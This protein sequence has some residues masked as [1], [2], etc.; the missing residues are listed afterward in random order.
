MITSKEINM[1]YDQFKKDLGIKDG[2]PKLLI[3]SKPISGSVAQIK[4]VLPEFAELHIDDVLYRNQLHKEYIYQV[5]YHEFTHIVD[6]LSYFNKKKDK[7]KWARFCSHIQN[8][9][10]LKLK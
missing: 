1:V 3:L 7:Y 9:M 5:L 6:E 8:F 2:I 10:L 4:R